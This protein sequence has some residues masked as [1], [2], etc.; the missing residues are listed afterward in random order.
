MAWRTDGCGGVL[1][2]GNMLIMMDA[3]ARWDDSSAFPMLYLD[4][5]LQW[6]DYL[7]LNGGCRL[8]SPQATRRRSDLW[9]CC[10]PA[11]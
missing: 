4:Q 6:A 3:I 8:S 11:A 7:A 2:A 5:L 10:W 1:F 9:G